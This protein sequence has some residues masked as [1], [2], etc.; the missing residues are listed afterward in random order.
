MAELTTREKLIDAA[1]TLFSEK[2]YDATSVDEIAQSIGM[3]GPIIYNYFKGKED[4]LNCVFEISENLF[5]NKA[6]YADQLPI[7]IHNGEELIKFTWDQLNYTMND[8]RAIKIRKFCTVEQYR[9]DKLTREATDHQYEDIINLY[10]EIFAYMMKEGTIK[11]C[12]PVT[13]SFE[14]SA[15]IA[16]L[17]Q[18]GDM[19]LDRR[20]EAVDLI[21]KHMDF[22]V[23][24]YCK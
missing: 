1:L 21:Q 24:T 18:L 6:E 19:D 4:L 9:L 15:P 12:D 17:V 7:H 13:L 11:K 20:D 3:T 5:F 23:K 14:F 8:D 22:F 10:T 16:I 2:G